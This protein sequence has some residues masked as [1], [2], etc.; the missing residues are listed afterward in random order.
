MPTSIVLELQHLATEPDTD[1]APLLRKALVIATKLK[2]DDFR[3]W[4]SSELNGYK[5]NPIP[6]YRKL[7]AE[8]RLK[9]PY[10]GLIPVHFPTQEM[11]DLF[12]Q[13]QVRD[14]L[15]NLIALL[16]DEGT[17]VFPLPP[18]AE[19]VL[20]RQ[21]DGLGLPPVRTVS[22]NQIEGIVEAV[23]TAILEW[24][25][26][27]ESEGILGE[28][29][30]FTQKEKERAINSPNIRIDNFQGILGN[31]NQSTISQNLTQTV[32]RG[33]FESL[34]ERLESAG[35]GRTEIQELKE[36]IQTDGEPKSEKELGS[37]VS[38][39]IG[40]M[41]SKAADGSWK[42]ALGAG[43][44]LLATAIKAYYGF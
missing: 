44:N 41:V 25:L 39:W 33:D 30:T 29:M 11:F 40:K 23:R 8:I 43:G 36:A 14:P 18:E 27:L 42:I 20:L 37:N 15:P 19:A 26:R 4:I 13:I 12:T 21:Q 38:G 7:R 1:V 31:V 24:T 35:I 32:K 3:I 2:R 34:R 22:R 6:D 17:I 5:A 16:D 9:N 28:G 10:H